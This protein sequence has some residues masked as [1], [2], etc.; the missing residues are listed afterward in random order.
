MDDLK[1][2]LHY[3]SVTCIVRKNGRYLICKRGP[4][5]E[6]FPNKWCVPGG[7]M[8][9]RDFADGKMGTVYHWLNVFEAVA[10]REIME[11]TGLKIRNIR[12]VT[13][14]AFVRPNGFS[15]VIVSMAADHAGGEVV[16]KD[17]E[18]VEH[19]WVALDE[20]KQYDLIP[21]IYD[22]LEQA[23]RLLAS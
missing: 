6:V 8:E 3:I 5:A 12:Y 20:V 7:K 15:T 23:E 10:E 17:D 22:Q 13:N 11:E 21:K 9:T 19:A 16:L 2:K 18:L 1:E 14:L 4:N